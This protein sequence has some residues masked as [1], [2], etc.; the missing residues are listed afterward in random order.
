M[1]FGMDF[2][3]AAE[4]ADRVGDSDK[5][6][7]DGDCKDVLVDDNAGKDTVIETCFMDSGLLT[8]GSNCTREARCRA[9]ASLTSTAAASNEPEF[10]LDADE[11]AAV[12]LEGTDDD[13][14]GEEDE[15]DDDEEERAFQD[16]LG[17]CSGRAAK[18]C[19]DACVRR[20]SFAISSRSNSS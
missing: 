11:A 4:E 3:D 5:V 19:I 18:K 7:V 10:A 17:S 15:V 14:E 12:G 6:D 20:T 8:G 9:A 16:W 2:A 1:L 13:N